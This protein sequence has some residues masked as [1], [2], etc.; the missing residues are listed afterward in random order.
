MADTSAHR[1]AEEWVTSH[2]LKE[3]F[4]GT[5]FSGRKLTLKWGGQ[6][7]FDAVS[8]DGKIVALVSASPARTANGNVA[9][10]P[11]RKLKADALYLLHVVGAERLLLIFTEDSLLKTFEKER[12][13]GR[14]PPEIELL[15]APLPKEI[16]SQVLAARRLA[17]LETSPRA[18][19][20]G[21]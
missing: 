12:D 9:A 10:G 11:V 5:D 16:Q 15:A 4:R 2:F 14:F 18:G 13:S 1:I 17:S 20:D 3:K 19:S 21:L 6:F 7:A 8:K